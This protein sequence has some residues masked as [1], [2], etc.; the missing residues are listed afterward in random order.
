MLR[1][2]AVVAA[3]TK[4]EGGGMPCEMPELVRKP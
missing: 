1:H 4:R 3:L 2:S